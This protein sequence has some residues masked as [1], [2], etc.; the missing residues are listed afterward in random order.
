MACLTRQLGLRIPCLCLQRL[1]LQVGHHT[2][3]MFTC[4]L[5]I[6]IPSL[7]FRGLCKAT[8]PSATEAGGPE[9]WGCCGGMLTWQELLKRKAHCPFLGLRSSIFYMG[10][11]GLGLANCCLVV[12]LKGWHCHFSEHEV[13]LCACSTCA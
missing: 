2:H 10:A 12:M 11:Q 13:T 6:Q 1:K 8:S 7:L 5:K 9:L 3:P 4:V